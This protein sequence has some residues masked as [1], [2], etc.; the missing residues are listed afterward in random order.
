MKKNKPT[1]VVGFV[2]ITCNGNTHPL[3]SSN[4]NRLEQFFR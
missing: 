4:S 1:L 3:L 2:T